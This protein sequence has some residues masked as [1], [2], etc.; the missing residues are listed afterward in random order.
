MKPSVSIRRRAGHPAALPRVRARVALAC[1]IAVA[2]SGCSLLGG[3]KDPPTI[4][5]P[6]PAAQADAA[7]PAVGWQLA[8]AQVQ[9]ARPVDSVRIAVRPTPQEMQVYKGAQ[10]AQRPGDML[11][12]T[13]LR[14]L[15]DSGKIPAVARAGAGVNADYRL[16][17]DVRRFESDY[18]GQAVPRA[19]IEVNAKLLHAQD[20]DVVAS[21]TFL[22]AVPATTPGVREVVDAF[23]RALAAAGRDIAGWTLATGRDH[24]GADHR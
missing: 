8:V 16:V 3:R 7:W 24:E 5:A 18:A 21:R 9:V 23:D 19:T 10:W 15:E 14:L 22:Q 11:E 1:L 2:A 6:Q 4:Y 20:R 12:R 17:L 13:V